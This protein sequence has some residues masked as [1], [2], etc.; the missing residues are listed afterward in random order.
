MEVVNS[1]SLGIDSPAP[2][3]LLLFL[4][5]LSEVIDRVILTCQGSKPK[6]SGTASGAPKEC[7]GKVVPIKPLLLYP[8]P[9]MLSAKSGP[10]GYPSFPGVSWSLELAS[11][12]PEGG[13][14]FSQPS[15]RLS[16]FF[17]ELQWPEPLCILPSALG[18]WKSAQGLSGGLHSSRQHTVM[19]ENVSL[20]SQ[21]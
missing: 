21:G 16:L 17:K 3:S 14:S 19:K 11:F 10:Q 20:G 1:S 2:P 9:P 15:L 5:S 18:S 7:K 8:V 6:P 13:I 4:P 12:S